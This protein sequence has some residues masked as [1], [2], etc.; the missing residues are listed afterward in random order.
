M[1]TNT[2]E[3]PS[4]GWYETPKA[5]AIDPLRRSRWC[6]LAIGA[7]VLAL[8]AA[9]CGGS[10]SK[11]S[12]SSSTDSSSLPAPVVPT[13]KEGEFGSFSAQ[14]KDESEAKTACATQQTELG[15]QLKKLGKQSEQVAILFQ[16]KTPGHINLKL[17]M[18]A[19]P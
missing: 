11:G 15:L 4:S 19:V 1:S 10:S 8:V 17:C 3:T 2:S 18:V 13:I 7:C 12:S 14:V 6:A 9:G 5:A 16:W